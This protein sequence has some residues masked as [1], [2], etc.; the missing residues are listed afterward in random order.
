MTITTRVGDYY[1]PLRR[2]EVLSIIRTIWLAT[3]TIGLGACRFGR[4]I[5][6]QY[7]QFRAK[8]DGKDV[9]VAYFKDVKWV[10]QSAPDLCWAAAL[11][12]ALV[13]QDVDIDQ[14]RIVERTYPHSE[15]A[16][17]R[18]PHTTNFLNWQLRPVMEARLRNGSVVWVHLDVFRRQA[19]HYRYSYIE[20]IGEELWSD[21]IV[22]AGIA[23]GHGQGHVVTVIGAAYP[24]NVKKLNSMD[25][26]GF[27]I[28]DPLNAKPLLVSIDDFYDNM[29]LIISVATFESAL[30]AT[31]Y[32][33]YSCREDDDKFWRK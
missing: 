19:D 15:E 28:Y 17:E 16:P 26:L 32:C 18:T 13:R 4:N 24:I 33:G 3:L 21:R 12:Q 23:T 5:N 29:E 20:A 22:L 11:E 10:R 9:L 7:A 25:M 1:G 2:R 30:S 14:E 8:L 6:A 27:L 31:L